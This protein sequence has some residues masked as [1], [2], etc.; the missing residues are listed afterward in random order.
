MLSASDYN[1]AMQALPLKFRDNDIK[2]GSVAEKDTFGLPIPYSG[3]FACVYKIKIK[4]NYYAL[5]FFLNVNHDKN[6]RYRCLKKFIGNN[7]LPFFVDFDF[8]ENG[9]LIKG[10]WYPLIK[11]HWVDGQTLDDYVKHHLSNSKVISLLAED[12]AELVFSLKKNNIAHGDLQHGN[13]LVTNSGLKLIDYDGLYCA[14]TRHLVTNE[15]GMPNYQHPK[16]TSVDISIHIDDFSA[17]IIY[18]SLRLLSLEKNFFNGNDTLIFEKFDFEFP[19]K[20]VGLNK[21]IKH[22]NKEISYYGKFIVND[23]LSKSVKDIPLFNRNNFFSIKDDG[24]SEDWW[25]KK[26][27]S[28]DSS[29]VNDWLKKK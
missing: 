1:D 17:W 22:K 3:N 28:P 6:E 12:F 11:M 21:C 7:N 25:K 27:S 4:Q 5:R 2:Q 10:S 14:D 23:L 15:I 16:R 26:L 8:Q 29:W 13:I 19:K 24:N 20:S 9:V 18:I